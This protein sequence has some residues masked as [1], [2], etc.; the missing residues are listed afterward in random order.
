MQSNHFHTF[1][2]FDVKMYLLCNTSYLWFRDCW[3]CYNK[4]KKAKVLQSEYCDWIIGST[5]MIQKIRIMIASNFH[6]I[7]NMT[8]SIDSLD[9]TASHSHI[10]HADEDQSWK[11]MKWWAA[12]LSHYYR[13]S[14]NP[15]DI[16]INNNTHRRYETFEVFVIKLDKNWLQY[17]K[18]VLVQCTF[19]SDVVLT[20]LYIF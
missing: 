19:W 20:I 3:W 5:K 4:S 13:I 16:N 8:E 9:S 6:K 11:K 2:L 1:L 7:K 12:A 17:Q 14:I 10:E 18:R 15:L